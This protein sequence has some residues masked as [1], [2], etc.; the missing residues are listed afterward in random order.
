MQLN[1]K[2]LTC[3]NVINL[4]IEV[5]TLKHFYFCIYNFEINSILYSKNCVFIFFVKGE[6][7]MQLSYLQ[8]EVGR[9]SEDNIRQQE[10]IT[11]LLSQIVDLQRKLRD[12]RKYYFYGNICKICNVTCIHLCLLFLL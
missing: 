11:Q 4:K 12:V 9:K 5:L 6:A 10:E 3:F 1:S 8:E 7:N 2:E